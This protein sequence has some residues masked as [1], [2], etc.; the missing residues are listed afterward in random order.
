[1]G[2]QMVALALG[3]LVAALLAGLG[4][5]VLVIAGRAGGLPDRLVGLFF[6]CMGVG[7]VPALL[8]PDASVLPRDMAP[9]AMGIGHGIVSLGFGALYVFVWRCFGP[10]TGWRSVVAIAGCDLLVVLF[11]LQGFVERFGVPGGWTLHCASVIRALALA[12][13]FGETLRY[14]A[15]MRRREAVGLADPLVVNRFALWSVWTGSMLAAI[16]FVIF[17]R[18]VGAYGPETDPAQKALVIGTLAFFG[19]SSGGALW[20]AFFPPDW[21]AARLRGASA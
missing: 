6:V 12:W 20:L 19:A 1:M 10:D 4:L 7:V 8:A 15:V 16:A 18:L 3:I 14:Q 13:A 11:S 5:R 2:S 21:Y 9:W 17:V